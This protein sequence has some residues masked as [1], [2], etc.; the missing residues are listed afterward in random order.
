MNNFDVALLQLLPTGSQ[1]RN[2]SKGLE[3]CKKAKQMGADIA[4]FPE[5]WSNGYNL[6]P[7]REEM[8][9]SAV[10]LNSDFIKRFV[11]VAKE[12]NMAVGITFLESYDP[13][14]RNSLVVIDRYGNI[15][16]HY[17]KV[18]TCVFDITER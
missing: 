10:E 6:M 11:E 15:V 5:M 13:T 7:D 4:L 18:H 17:A 2:L 12:L 14:P 1:E 8:A 3:F 9:E 16:L